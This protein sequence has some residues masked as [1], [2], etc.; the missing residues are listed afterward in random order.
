MKS[1]V[2]VRHGKSDWSGAHADRDRPVGARGAR[3]AA[4]T[5][6][7]LAAHGPSVQLAV[8]SPATRATATWALVAEQLDHPVS[9]R[10]EEAV[11]TFDGDDLLEVVRD[12]PEDLE[13]VALVGHNPAMEE[14][15][16]ELSGGFL[17]M[18]TSCLAVLQWSGGWAEAGGGSA[19]LLAHGRPPQA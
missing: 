1:L 5:G 14:L 13:C 10:P 9:V 4:E 11:Y 8:V 7:W 17:P 15:L 19:D 3:Q 12:L 6:R 18:P 16:A 2:L